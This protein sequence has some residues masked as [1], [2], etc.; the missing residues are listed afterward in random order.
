MKKVKTEQEESDSM[1]NLNEIKKK[2]QTESMKENIP[3][4]IKNDLGISGY[5]KINNE[6]INYKLNLEVESFAR[7]KDKIL[8]DEL[9]KDS[10]EIIGKIAKSVSE[11]G[12]KK[13]KKEYGVWM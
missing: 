7:N 10:K 12:I 4:E 5:N 9:G 3:I 11:V 13:H 8:N 6:Y 2:V 1:I